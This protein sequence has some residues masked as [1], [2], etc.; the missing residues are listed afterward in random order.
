MFSKDAII[1]KI[2][3]YIIR[4]CTYV[5]VNVRLRTFCNRFFSLFAP[6]GPLRLIIIV[7]HFPKES[8]NAAMPWSGKNTGPKPLES[9]LKRC[10]FRERM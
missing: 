7:R 4:K 1:N 6:L 8:G 3:A 5:Y 10:V 2:L 9:D